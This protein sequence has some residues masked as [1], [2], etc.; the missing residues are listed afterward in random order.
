MGYVL[1]EE[2]PG[3]GS[4]N[5]E[6]DYLAE[7]ANRYLFPP[8][9]KVQPHRAPWKQMVEMQSAYLGIQLQKEVWLGA[10]EVLTVRLT[11]LMSSR[12]TVQCSQK[13]HYCLTPERSN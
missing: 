10:W 13:D 5:L 12:V 8:V 9:R 4:Q 6:G 2:S 3:V 1:V 11:L 7:K